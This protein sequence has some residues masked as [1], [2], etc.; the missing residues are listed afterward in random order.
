MGA[1]VGHWKDLT[2]AQ[3]L[4]NS[5][6]IPGVIEQDIKRNNPIDR[7]AVALALGKSIKWNREKT[8]VDGDVQKVDIGATMTWTSSVEYDQKEI[9]LK[10]A[11]LP[12]LLDNFIMDVYGTEQNYEAQALW[13]IK[14]GMARFLGDQLIYGDTTYSAGNLEMDGYHAWAAENCA[15]AASDGLLDI[16]MASAPLSIAKLRLMIDSM[17]SGCDYILI[18][19][20]LG[21]WIDAAYEEKGFAGLAYNAAGT[22]MGFTRGINDIGMPI[23][24]FQGIPL[25]RSDYLVA[26]QEDTG[27]GT[28]VRAKWATSTKVY[29]IFGVK[30]GDV[31]AGNPGVTLGFGNPEMKSKLYKVEY[32]DKLEDYD[33]KGLRLV[34]YANTLLGSK[35]CLGR[36]HDITDAAILV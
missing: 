19:P 6:L 25:V 29:S 31:F 16:D 33:A 22:M 3:K 5:Q 20:C 4:T 35:L 24:Y 36:I 7:V 8:V 28:T 14:K 27:R 23:T 32:F 18:P 30:S 34:T 1:V 9:E 17:K 11:A 13:E 21:I 10:R 26:E 15:A 12:R 2:E